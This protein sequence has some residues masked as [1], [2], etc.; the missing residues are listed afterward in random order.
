MQ[1]K[2]NKTN[3]KHMALEHCTESNNVVFHNDLLKD[4]TKKV[5]F[6]NPFDVT[7]LDSSDKLPKSFIERDC[8][9]HLGGRNIK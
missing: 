4:I 9:L 5:G 7:K 6:G 8:L 3:K 1:C 2:N